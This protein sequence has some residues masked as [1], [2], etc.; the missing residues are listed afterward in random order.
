MHDQLAM[1]SKL[2]NEALNFVTDSSSS[3]AVSALKGECNS[4]EREQLNEGYKP[5]MYKDSRG[6]RTIGIGFNLEKNGARSAIES[7]GANYNE[8][9]YGTQCL[10][11]W[12]IKH[13]F[14]EDMQTAINCA[15]HF[16]SGIGDTALSA[17]ADMAFNLGCAKLQQFKNFRAALEQRRFPEAIK[18]LKTSLLCRQ[19]G[20]RCDRN[21]ACIRQGLYE[22]LYNFIFKLKN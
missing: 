22:R 13:L 21:A 18:E 2:Y 1:Y 6:I 4:Y 17:V 11:D 15:K 5:C 7:V 12:Q 14:N 10:E 20:Q 3:H 8:V 19:V 16:I 9:L